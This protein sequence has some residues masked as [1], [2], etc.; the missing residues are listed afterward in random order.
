MIIEFPIQISPNG[1]SIGPI[2]TYTNSAF[3]TSSVAALSFELSDLSSRPYVAV[4]ALQKDYS[5]INSYVSEYAL[6]LEFSAGTVHVVSYTFEYLSYYLH[7]IL[8]NKSVTLND[9]KTTFPEAFV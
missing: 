3:F 1:S 6:I 8:A 7:A 5:D 9:F 2:T 4:N